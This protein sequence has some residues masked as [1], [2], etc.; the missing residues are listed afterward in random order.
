MSICCVELHAM[1]LTSS[2]PS[3]LLLSECPCTIGQVIGALR[4]ELDKILMNNRKAQD[5]S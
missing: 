3:V 1:A 2:L 4:T 5:Q